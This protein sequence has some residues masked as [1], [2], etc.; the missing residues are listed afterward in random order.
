MLDTDVGRDVIDRLIPLVAHLRA[1]IPLRISTV[2]SMVILRECNL[3]MELDCRNLDHTDIFFDKLRQKYVLLSYGD[4]I[5]HVYASVFNALKRDRNTWASCLTPIS[6]ADAPLSLHILGH[7]LLESGAITD[8]PPS[9]CSDSEDEHDIQSDNNDAL[10]AMQD[11]DL[12]GQ[13][14][15]PDATNTNY[16]VLNTHFDLSAS[17][18]AREPYGRGNPQARLSWTNKQ[19][20]LA[21]KAPVANGLDEFANKVSSSLDCFLHYSNS[22]NPDGEPLQQERCAEGR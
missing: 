15:Y 10:F 3:P 13:F 1:T 16:C 12:Y 18:L 9:P 4:I 19:R 11:E 14:Y 5:S 20:A 21:A 8:G 7:S 17:E 6:A 22:F 2:L